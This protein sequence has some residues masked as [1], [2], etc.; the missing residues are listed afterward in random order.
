VMNIATTSATEDDLFIL[1]MHIFVA[2]RALAL[3]R[4]SV[5]LESF[6]EVR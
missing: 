4:L 5:F 6:A 3:N 1:V 2:Y